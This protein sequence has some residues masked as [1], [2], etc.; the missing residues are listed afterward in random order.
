MENS[1][2]S[3]WD[4]EGGP[5]AFEPAPVAVSVFSMPPTLGSGHFLQNGAK[6][7]GPRP[8]QNNDMIRKFVLVK[9]VLVKLVLKNCRYCV[10]TIYYTMILRDRQ[11]LFEKIFYFRRKRKIASGIGKM[12]ILCYDKQNP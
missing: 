4:P 5:G 8:L 12:A 6:K 2:S 10:C 11:G 1:T 9:F 7:D 3:R